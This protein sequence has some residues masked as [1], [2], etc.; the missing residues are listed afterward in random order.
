MIEYEIHAGIGHKSPYMEALKLYMNEYGIEIKYMP[1]LPCRK[2]EGEER[3]IHIH[4]IGRLY[5]SNDVNSLN[6]L[7]DQID[8]YLS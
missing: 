3:I 1:Y 4:R 5:S 6:K 2:P 7:L 8:E